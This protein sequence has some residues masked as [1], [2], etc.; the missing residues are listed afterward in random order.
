MNNFTDKGRLFLVAATLTVAGLARPAAAQT[1]T[2]IPLSDTGGSPYG[3]AIGPGG[4]LWFTE[5]SDNPTIARISMDGVVTEFPI[6]T[7]YAAPGGIAP[8]PDG[9]L[10]FT[11]ADFD[12]GSVSLIGRI[13]PAGVITEFPLSPLSGP[14]DI[15]A[16]PD[17]NL[18]FTEC[19]I[20]GNAIGRITTAGVITEFRLPTSG[21]GYYPLGIA[22]GPDGNLW[23]T[24]PYVNRIV[25]ITTKGIITEFS[26]PDA[27]EPSGI[28]AGPDGN[29]WFTE[30]NGNKIGRIT[31]AGLI[32]EFAIPT[33]RSEPRGITAGPDGSLWFTEYGGNKIGRIT[34]AGL[35]T[36]LAIPTSR[37]GPIGITVGRNRELWFTEIS[38]NQIGRISLAFSDVVDLSVGPDGETR[39]LRFDS[40]SGQ[41]AFDSVDGAG[42]VSRGSPYGPY[43]GWTARAISTGADG[44][45]RVLWTSEGGSASLWLVGSQGNQASFQF[46]AISGWSA[47]D[48]AAGV[49][50]TTHLLWTHVDGSVALWSVDGSGHVL[51]NATYGP[52]P[53]WTALAI[54]DG[55]DGLTRLLWKKADGTAGLSIISSEGIIATHRYGPADRW[56]ATDLGVGG[57]NQTR[58]LWSHPDGRVAIGIVSGTGEVQYGPISSS[59]EGLTARHIAAGPDGSA[60]VL[61]TDGRGG[62]VVWLLSPAGVFQDLFDLT[63][64][65]PSGGNSWNLTVQVIAA[66]GPGICLYRPSMGMVFHTTFELRRSGNSVS[67]V[68]EDP[69]DWESYTATVNGANFTATSPT[70]DSGG[71]MCVHYKQTSSLSGSFSADGNHLTATEV[72]SLTLDSGEVVTTTFRWSASHI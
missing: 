50:G 52:Y 13:T 30:S 24:E 44:L 31:P 7:D 37:G 15:T 33:T 60:R 45:T 65:T 61:F 6:P 36:E 62:A 3:V 35:I 68:F 4:D 16:G 22:A 46:G 21:M 63:S 11:A 49:A 27:S 48:V 38:G 67:F 2:E 10:W 26:I 43:P 19:N 71:G 9:N 72:W 70:V 40:G 5:F 8:G 58:I 69:I 59:L 41:T 14:C 18:W 12:M 53:G 66:N 56:N 55:A 29:L 32:T 42:S 28:T 64:P 17:G 57:D 34:T 25:R 39:V 20:N 54:S 47:V 1:I 23:F 51:T